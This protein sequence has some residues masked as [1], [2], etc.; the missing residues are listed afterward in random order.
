MTTGQTMLRSAILDPARA[1]P[2]GLTD[3]QGRPAGRR[4]S[5]YRNN[6]AVSLTEALA[7]GFPACRAVLGPEMFG[8]MAGE[9]LRQSPPCS[10][11]MA[12]YGHD[13]DK[14]LA[15]APQ[16]EKHRWLADLARFEYLLRVSYH[17][18]D[19]VPVSADHFAALPPEELGGQRFALAPALRFLQS[20]WAVLSIWQAAMT[21]DPLATLPQRPENVLI[22]RPAYDPEAHLLH[23]GDAVFLTVLGD[24]QTL[25]SAA[26]AA[27][28]IAE[29]HDP[30]RLLSLLLQ[31]GAL[32]RPK[33]ET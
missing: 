28:A 15:A 10:P 8:G 7:E 27:A 12:D 33:T 3:G 21:G 31:N 24:G 17:A 22:L 29:G 11:V 1:V 26:L 2:T 19:A 23:P 9:Y 25:E 18:A 5:V 32:T 4:F 20:R 16:L 14:F 13:L 6:V 30:T